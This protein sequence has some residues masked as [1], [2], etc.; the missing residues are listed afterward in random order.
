MEIRYS[1]RVHWLI[2]SRM[3]SNKQTPN[4]H[5]RATVAKTGDIFDARE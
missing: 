4:V 1:A 2:P 3:T 5:E